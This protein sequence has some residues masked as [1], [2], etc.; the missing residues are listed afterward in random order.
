M[1]RISRRGF[2][3]GAAG[4]LGAATV[5]PTAA[6]AQRRREPR[7]LASLLRETANKYG[8]PGITAAV[9]RGDA[10]VEQAA[11]G[12]TA[13]ENGRVVTVE[14][15]FHWGSVSK[16]FAATLVAHLVQHGELSY[17]TTLRDAL[18]GVRMH[19][20]YERATVRDVLV[21]RAGLIC[22]PPLEL[23]DP[24]TARKLWYDIPNRHGRPAEQRAAMTRHALSLPPNYMPPATESI[25]SNV[26]YSILGHITEVVTRTPYEDL[27]TDRVFH[28][29]GMT[30]T[31]VGGWPTAGDAGQPR[32]HNRPDQPG[33]PAR[34]VGLDAPELPRW[35]AGAGGLHGPIT[36]LAAFAIDQVRGAHG[37]GRILDVEGYRTLHTPQAQGD[38]ALMYPWMNHNG[39]VSI[40]YGSAFAETSHGRMTAF[41]G[42]T[43]TF[44]ADCKLL[45]DARLGFVALAN[46]G[47]TEVGAATQEVF[48]HAT[49]VAAV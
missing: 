33:A 45:P 44:M 28:P 49:G 4:L 1:S 5:G 21:H 36:D 6:A 31:C 15:R 30:G 37:E 17:G 23:T 42:S 41:A 43:G 12:T 27:L 34:A 8:I 11:Y 20:A 7:E 48:E 25:Y 39:T 2:G 13:T 29:L 40:G 9:I 16:R 10:V 19:Q 14:D 47:W 3:V 32:G 22:F 18:P 26:G 35:L 46:G 38:L 24:A